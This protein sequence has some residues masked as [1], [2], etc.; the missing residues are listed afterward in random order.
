MSD[1]EFATSAYNFIHLPEM[2]LKAPVT[3]RVVPQKNKTANETLIDGYKE[4]LKDEGKHSGYIQLDIKALTPLFIGGEEIIG[5]KDKEMRFFAPVNEPLIPGSTL[6]GMV[7]NIFKIVTCGNFRRDEDFNDQRLFFRCLMAAGPGKIALKGT[8]K[9][10]I[11]DYYLRRMKSD[12]KKADKKNIKNAQPGF[13]VR[14]HGDYFLC[15]VNT[16]HKILIY[17]YEEKYGPIKDGLME[18]DCSEI[19]W[20]KDE[21]GNYKEVYIITGKQDPIMNREQID[22]FMEETPEEL[23]YKLGKQYISYFRTEETDWKHPV[24]IEE[25]LILDYK[26][27][28]NR[29]G[30][31]VLED[32]E[33][34]I[35]GDDADNISGISGA[36][37]LSP[38]FYVAEQGNIVS[39][40]HGQS[41]RIPYKNKVGDAV[42]KELAGSDIDFAAEVFG[43]KE[44]WAGRIFF[45]DAVPVSE[46]KMESPDYVQPL[47]GPNP[48][49]FQLY[50]EQPDM[51]IANLKYWDSF[52]S[53][54]RG[55]KL[56]WHKKIKDNSWVIS[57]DYRSEN[58]KRSG[59]EKLSKKINPIKKDARFQSRIR[60]REL[61]D[62]ELGALLEVF[63]L[64]GYTGNAVYK[65][66]MGKPLGMG[67]ISIEAQ[68][69]EETNNYAGLFSDNKWNKGVSKKEI[70]DYV[71]AFE[72][73][74]IACGMEKEW[75][76]I[77]NELVCM[78]EWT[79][80]EK[81][82]WNQR[83]AMMKSNFKEKDVDPRFLQRSPLPLPKNVVEGDL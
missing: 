35:R 29:R 64:A 79:N 70:Q 10:G 72:N 58:D 73:Y 20:K 26:E 9:N 65:V 63:Y 53:K 77:I 36:D 27:D 21:Q 45:E 68:L 57:D 2:V 33:G 12:D 42:P 83:T 66:G 13:L 59:K 40:G 60:F 54:I 50:L 39:F 16:L 82:D 78:L 80:T 71:T 55:Y 23:R 34:V 3:D 6:R 11:Y 61:S 52:G 41:Y 38:C 51:D 15:R 1:N 43:S 74:I 19:A 49:S 32:E 76:S 67:S 30:I 22:K 62:V 5:E 7:K 18:K 37:R 31:D 17:D 25:R 4:Y 81:S 47:M 75:Q 14:A 28:K 69:F 44:L 24:P 46:V 56:Y 8:D 48:T